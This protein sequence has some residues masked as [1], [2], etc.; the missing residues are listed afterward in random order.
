MAEPIIINDGSL[1]TKSVRI[2]GPVRDV[3]S[4]TTVTFTLPA[5]IAIS[6]TTQTSGTFA[7]NVWTVPTLTAE[8]DEYIGVVFQILDNSQAP[9]EVTAV[10]DNPE[11]ITISNNT[12]IIAIDGITCQEIVDCTLPN[13]PL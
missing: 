7:A 2:P 4:A 12:L 1:I 3:T 5:G 8:K 6:S 9:Y 11:D 10:V 13:I